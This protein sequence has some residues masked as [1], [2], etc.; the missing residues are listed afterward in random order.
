MLG[1]HPTKKVLL[2]PGKVAHCP[3]KKKK[4]GPV[5]FE[6]NSAKNAMI[7]KQIFHIPIGSSDETLG[8]A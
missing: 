2:Q 1:K 5:S 8:P 7:I 4:K 3:K 6:L